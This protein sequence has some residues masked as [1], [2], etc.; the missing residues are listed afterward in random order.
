M[1]ATYKIYDILVRLPKELELG[2]EDVGFGQ[3]DVSLMPKDVIDLNLSF[4]E[5]DIHWYHNWIAQNDTAWLSSGITKSNYYILRFSDIDFFISP[6]GTEIF[7]DESRNIS[8]SEIIHKFF[9]Q[10]LPM[11]MNYLDKEVIHAS[12]ILVSGEAIA[13]VGNGGYGKSTIAASLIKEGNKLIS[14]DAVPLIL[15]HN[16]IYTASGLNTINLWPHAQKILNRTKKDSVHSKSYVVLSKEEYS[17]GTFPLKKI[18]F[19]KP[20]QD[21]KEISVNKLSKQEAAMELVRAAH[22]LDITNKQM[23][24]NQLTILTKISGLLSCD[25]LS[26]PANIPEPKLISSFILSDLRNPIYAV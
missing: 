24:Q 23:L 16:K 6:S 25:M 7:Y 21:I 18:Y 4:H 22:R 15:N 1:S 2:L 14:D 8:K 5:D 13:F 17:M 10:I 19:L 12:S 11:T 3:A 20:S 9:N 26:F